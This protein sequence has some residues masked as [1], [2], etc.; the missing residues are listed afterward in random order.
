MTP[1]TFSPG[2]LVMIAVVL[3]NLALLGA[4]RLPYAVR[5]VAAQGIVLGE[6]PL[7][8]HSDHRDLH[9]FVFAAC[10]IGLKGL[11]FPWLLLRALREAEVRREM[12]PFLGYSS[13]LLLGI[14]LLGVSLWIGA[15][16]P[17]AGVGAA[18][19]TLVVPVALS[20]MLTG[21]QLIVTRR[22]VLTQVLGYLVFENGIF[23]FG[24]PLAR[25][26]PVLIE[27]GV[28]LDVFVA[29][30]VMGIAMFHINREFDHIDARQ[31]T[32]LTD[33]TQ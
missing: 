17:S 16:L 5:I 7:V 24:V 33:W 18:A 30:F 1:P 13:S 23:A 20:T 22:T 19:H 6:L 9:T 2:D 28:L 31:L 32:M 3:T 27:M 26:A 29:V 15:R 14:A 12:E 25:Q 10:A 8:L 21:L 4:S 11:V